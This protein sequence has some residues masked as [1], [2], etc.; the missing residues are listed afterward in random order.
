MKIST[1]INNY[2]TDTTTRNSTNKSNKSFL[3]SSNTL[4]NS[5][6]YNE[7]S[8]PNDK[9]FIGRINNTFMQNKI[10]NTAKTTQTNNSTTINRDVDREYILSQH[11]N[12]NN[13]INYLEFTGTDE[14]NRSV[15]SSG[16]S[17]GY[18]ENFDPEN[19]VI[20]VRGKDDKGYFEAY[21]ELSKIDPKNCSNIEYA[22]LEGYYTGLKLSE[23]ANMSEIKLPFNFPKEPH[24]DRSNSATQTYN[25]QDAYKNAIASGLYDN[26]SIAKEI[27]ILSKLWE[28]EFENLWN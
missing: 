7:E 19:P 17:L 28:K 4:D 15:T 6:S 21:V 23:G 24:P 14:I 16:G 8:I 2:N 25:L 18:P 11:S 22:A 26:N 20:I 1:T 10:M 5:N 9:K 12:K 27:A 13:V 3:G